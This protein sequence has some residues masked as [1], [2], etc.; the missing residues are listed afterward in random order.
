MTSLRTSLRLRASAVLLASAYAAVYAAAPASVG[1]QTLVRESKPDTAPGVPRGMMPP[2]GKCRVWM[3]GV[4]ATRQPAPT[5]CATALRQKPA[6]ARVIY[7]PNTVEPR[8]AGLEA[9]RE[10]KPSLLTPI[11]ERRP[12]LVND[13]A[14]EGG[15]ASARAAQRGAPVATRADS[16]STRVASPSAGTTPAAR[17]GAPASV[18]TPPASPKSVPPKKPERP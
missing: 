13:R 8:Q 10:R 17:Q 18:P 1:A 5:D 16:H 9:A 3:D 14:A 2:S 7:G 15:A 4:P 11:G 12:A 6:N